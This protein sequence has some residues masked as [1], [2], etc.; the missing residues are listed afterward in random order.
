[1]TRYYKQRENRGDRLGEKTVT[2]ITGKAL[3]YRIY[4]LHTN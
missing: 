2:Y 4:R 3:V 1:M